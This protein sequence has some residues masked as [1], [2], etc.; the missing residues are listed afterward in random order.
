MLWQSCSRLIKIWHFLA[1]THCCLCIK[2]LPTVSQMSF[3]FE[4]NGIDL[5]DVQVLLHWDKFLLKTFHQDADFFMET[6]HYMTQRCNLNLLHVGGYNINHTSLTFSLKIRI[7]IFQYHMWI[8]QW[9]MHYREYSDSCNS[10]RGLT[11]EGG[12]GTLALVRSQ[13]FLNPLH[14]RPV[15]SCWCG[16]IPQKTTKW[17]SNQAQTPRNG[18]IFFTTLLNLHFD[19]FP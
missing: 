3:I 7:K 5:S 18:T 14:S 12:L 6:K 16:L 8:H 13:V 9:K 4:V 19:S 1:C 2:L 11:R 17:C 10:I 15:W